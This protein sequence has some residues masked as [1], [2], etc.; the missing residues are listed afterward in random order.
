M[1]FIQNYRRIKIIGQILFWA[2]SLAF[3]LGSFYVAPGYQFNF[4]T[5]FFKVIILNIG[6]AFGVYMNILILIPRFLKKKNYIFYTFWL[7][8]TLA[9]S[10]LIILGLFYLLLNF[11]RPRLFSTYFFTTAS[12]IGITTLAKLLKDW[13]QLQDISLRYNKVEREKLEAELNSLK[14]QVNPHFLF[15]SLN[16]IY[17]LSLINSPKTPKMILMLSDLMRHVLYESRENFIPLKKEIEFTR[18]FIELQRIR[19]SDKVAIN[20][21]VEGEIQNKLIIPLIFEPF[22]DNAF[23]HGPKS[24]DKNAYINIKIRIDQDWLYFEVENN[25]GPI[26]QIQHKAHGIGLKNAQKRLEYLYQKDQFH[27][28]ITKKENIFNVQLQL[29]LKSKT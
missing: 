16:N 7:V 19:L 20:F 11:S 25:Y 24:L 2:C 3:A 29:K 27:L 4:T 28:D 15:N 22:V 9:A 17:S 6:L 1:A 21:E 12:Y 18:N 13:V 14:A 23:K 10:S 26:D 5:D 8:L